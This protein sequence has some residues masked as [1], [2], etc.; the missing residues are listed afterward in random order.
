MLSSSKA[1]D[2]WDDYE[3]SIDR[4]DDLYDS[5]KSANSTKKIV[6]VATIAS[7]LVTGYLW[8]KYMKNKK[9]CY[10]NIRAE[11]P[12]G[13]LMLNPGPNGIVLTYSF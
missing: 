12:S 11:K 3:S 8:W 4:P 7:G 6:G 10:G 9:N 1:N 5:Y 13:Q 2:K